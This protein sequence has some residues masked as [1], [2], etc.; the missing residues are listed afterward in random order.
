MTTNQYLASIKRLGLSPQGQATAKALGVTVRQ[1]GRY[2]SGE[3]A[4]PPT[5][6]RLL[7][8]LT[9]LMAQR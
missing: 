9:A 8:A 4:I 2:A 6:A 7:E 5:L 3:N 1:L